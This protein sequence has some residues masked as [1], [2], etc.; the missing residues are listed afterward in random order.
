MITV[1]IPNNHVPERTYAVRTML[2]HFCG[3]AIEVIPNDGVEGYEMK[4]G[5]KSIFIADSFF[6]KIFDLSSY[7][8]IDYLPKKIIQ[9]QSVGLDNILILFGTEQLEITRDS[10]V[11]HVDLF[12][13]LFFMLTRWEESICTKKDLHDRFPASEALVVKEGFILRPIVDEYVSLLKQWLTTL[14]YPVP[15]NKNSFRIV[16]TCDVDIPFYWSSK[17]LWKILGGRLRKHLNPLKSF[18]DYSKYKEVQKNISK[19]PY[20][21]FNYLM[22][23]AEKNS[24]LFQFNFI[25]GGKTK[26]EGNYQLDDQ[27][28]K[29]LIEE[30]KSRRHHLGLHP[31]YNAGQDVLLIKSEKDTLEKYIET[32]ITKSRQHFLRCTIPETWSNL[33]EAGLTEDSTM[34]YAAEP[35][36]RCGTCHAY[37][38]FDIYQRKQL[39][40]LE[41]PLL[42]MDVSLRFYKKLSIEESINLCEKIKTEVKKHNG[43]FVFLWHNS[44]LSEID[45]WS[46]WK[47]VLENLM[48]H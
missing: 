7:A 43:E 20:N 44:T 12:A 6:G 38:I 26:Y 11:C 40:I 45:G 42:V 19:D 47:N 21:T 3:I 5:D 22:N 24:N 10:I 37:P 4:W 41:S 13:G 46:D 32:T 35:G 14:G 23:L 17:P 28:I 18:T 8:H 15:E 33:A 2:T 48:L 27:P 31:S 29:A 9:S 39:P 36:F 25:A 34:G 16:P 1:H 30:I